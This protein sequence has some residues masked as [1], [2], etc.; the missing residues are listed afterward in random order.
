MGFCNSSLHIGIAD[1]LSALLLPQPP[2]TSTLLQENSTK[3][4]QN[5][6]KTFRSIVYVLLMGFHPTNGPERRA[7]SLWNLLFQAMRDFV[8]PPAKVR[9]WELG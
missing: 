4:R 3:L 8:L 9:P 5:P 1:I 7:I 2:L 6:L